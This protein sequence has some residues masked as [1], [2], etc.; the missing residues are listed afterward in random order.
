MTANDIV[1]GSTVRVLRTDRG[2]GAYS[3]GDDRYVGRVGDVEKIVSY[4]Y[5][6]PGFLIRFDNYTFQCPADCLELITPPLPGHGPY[7][8]HLAQ[9]LPP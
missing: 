3:R 9:E 5:A 1:P 4:S 8:T 2:W 7:N 6:T